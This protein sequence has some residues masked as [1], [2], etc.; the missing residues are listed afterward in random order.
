M[1]CDAHDNAELLLDDIVLNTDQHG[2][3]SKTKSNSIHEPA[4]HEASKFTTG[5]FANL[6]YLAAYNDGLR[7]DSPSPSAAYHLLQVVISG[8]YLIHP[9]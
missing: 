3:Q 5:H 2:S 9:G 1:H 8:E 4:L 7:L 6:H